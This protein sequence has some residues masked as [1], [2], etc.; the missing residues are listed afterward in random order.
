MSTYTAVIVRVSLT[1]VKER[2]SASFEAS[3]SIK[4]VSKT[5]RLL[6]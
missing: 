1:E 3:N 2:T 4:P 6:I 5:Q